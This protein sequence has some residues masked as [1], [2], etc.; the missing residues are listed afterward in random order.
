MIM[1]VSTLF[2]SMR[3]FNYS[4]SVSRRWINRWWAW[5]RLSSISAESPPEFLLEPDGI[6]GVR[7]PSARLLSFRFKATK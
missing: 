2:C 6:E 3:S 7:L 5:V 4:I 1:F